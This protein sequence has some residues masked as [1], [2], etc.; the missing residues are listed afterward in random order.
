MIKIAI[1]I[2]SVI[3]VLICIVLVCRFIFRKV[4]DKKL[5][6]YQNELLQRHY[7]EVENMYRQVRGWRHDYKNHIQ[8]MKNHLEAGKYDLLA[9]YLK[10]LN[11]DLIE[12]DTVLKTGNVM[13][14][15]IINSK[16][17]LAKNKGIKTSATAK[18]PEKLTV[19]QTDFCVIISNL[20]DNAIEAVMKIEDESNRFIRVYVGIFKGQLYISVSNSVGT[21]IKKIAKT[22]YTTKGNGHGFGLKRIDKIAAK[23]GGYVNRQDEGDVFATEVML[24][25]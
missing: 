1:I 24:P 25:V 14:D 22:Y 16:L 9:D 10:T 20:M 12:I 23:Y 6:I 15:A 21:Q 13:A 17:T 19:S 11:G 5:E 4:A 7:E 18:L 3:A 2:V 8:V